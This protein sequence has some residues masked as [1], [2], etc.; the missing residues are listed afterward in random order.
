MT[1]DPIEARLKE[2]GVVLPAPLPP[3]ANYVPF[4]QI[5]SEHR[6]APD[7]VIFQEQHHFFF[8]EFLYLCPAIVRV[9]QL[10][11]EGK[12]DAMLHDDG[13]KTL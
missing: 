10:T 8:G 7:I 3:T 1:R 13:P 12:I 11:C 4:K 9:V 6:V 2:I 5:E